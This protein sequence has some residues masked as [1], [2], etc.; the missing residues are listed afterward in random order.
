MLTVNLGQLPH[1]SLNSFLHSY[2]VLKEDGEGGVEDDAHVLD[3]ARSSFSLALK[4]VNSNSVRFKQNIA[5]LV[6]AFKFL[7]YFFIFCRVSRKKI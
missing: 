4:G 1:N 6:N 3:S 5:L 2:A 7:T